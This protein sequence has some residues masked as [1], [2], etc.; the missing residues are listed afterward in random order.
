[1][2]K[3]TGFEQRLPRG[4][5]YSRAITGDTNVAQQ[6]QKRRPESNLDIK[7]STAGISIVPGGTKLIRRHQY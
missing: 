3:E 5:Y 4:L 7:Y 2:E 6:D 1:M